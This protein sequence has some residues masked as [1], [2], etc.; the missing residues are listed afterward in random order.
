MGHRHILE[1][2]DLSECTNLHKAIDFS[3]DTF[4]GWRDIDPRDV[5]LNRKA[6]RHNLGE[7]SPWPIPIL[8]SE[9]K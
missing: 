9:F 3:L 1:E 2:K 6:Y 5:M 8:I 7:D 4:G